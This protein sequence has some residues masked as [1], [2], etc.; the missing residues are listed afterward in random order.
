MSEW[1][2]EFTYAERSV[3][4]QR[5]QHAQDTVA[6]VLDCIHPTHQKGDSM[7]TY[8]S[9]QDQTTKLYAFRIRKNW[10]I[11]HE[12]AHI[13]ASARQARLAALEWIRDYTNAG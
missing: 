1:G 4:T 9:T 8:T 7:L 2:V 11:V 3:H 10:T 5:R 6:A 13:Y 12:S